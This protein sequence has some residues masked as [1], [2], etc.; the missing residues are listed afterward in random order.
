MTT[1]LY[2]P[3]KNEASF[4]EMGF[5]IEDLKILKQID[6]SSF[7]TNS[8]MKLIEVNPKQLLAYFYGRSLFAA[9]L[10]RMRNGIVIFTGGTDQISPAVYSGIQLLRNR[11]FAVACVVVANHILLP[12]S[13]DRGEFIR[14][15]PK[16]K[17]L[18]KK[19]I[20]HPH[21]VV[22]P[23]VRNVDRKFDTQ[24]IS[25]VSVCWLGNETNPKRKGLDRVLI[26]ISA[27]TKKGLNASVTI[28]GG[29]EPGRAY[30]QSLADQLSI[31]EKVQFLGNISD[32][33]KNELF[34]NHDF[35][36]Q[37]S[38]FEGFGMAAVEALLSGQVVI[39]SN[40]GGLSDSIGDCGLIVDA[41]ELDEISP[42]E[43]F[44]DDFLNLL[45]LFKRDENEIQ[46]R[47]HRF[48]RESRVRAVKACGFHG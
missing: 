38:R 8:I 26:L 37:L 19:L 36:L 33:E 34:R 7:A 14:I 46:K 28:V 40:R 16:L 44:I 20:T 25:A 18:Q 15:L 41:H 43:S 9:V 24:A 42:D 17:W 27:L 12:S 13:A 48:S 32:N 23:L 10:V 30:L 5:Y 1:A 2:S 31:S 35:Y 11:I 45:R 6:E 4:N 47:E 3:V 29:G 22:A 39:H 21:S